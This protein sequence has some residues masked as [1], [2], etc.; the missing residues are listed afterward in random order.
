LE[1]RPDGVHYTDEGA[2]AATEALAAELRA[3][4]EV[5]L[6]APSDAPVVMG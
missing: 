4:L 3:S 1:T 6:L 2:D 5:P